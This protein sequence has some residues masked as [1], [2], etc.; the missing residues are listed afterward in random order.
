MDA[1]VDIDVAEVGIG[2]KGGSWERFERKLREPLR[3]RPAKLRMEDDDMLSRDKGFSCD[4]IFLASGRSV[5][6]DE[7]LFRR[8]SSSNPPDMLSEAVLPFVAGPCF[9]RV[10]ISNPWNIS[11][12]R[13]FSS[14]KL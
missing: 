12:S 13:L 14:S 2:G 3:C 8:P 6:S 1:N 5:Q 7:I 11:I 10:V 4:G 9:I